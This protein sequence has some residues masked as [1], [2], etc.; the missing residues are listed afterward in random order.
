[1]ALF[2]VHKGRQISNEK[3]SLS[4]SGF[5]HILSRYFFRGGGG[6]VIRQ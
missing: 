1:M 5:K 3:L 4:K 2:I 6:D